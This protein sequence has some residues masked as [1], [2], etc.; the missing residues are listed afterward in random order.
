M[1]VE[2][3]STVDQQT[4][5]A[6]GPVSHQMPAAVGSLA[7]QHWWP[8][9]LNLRPL[10]KNSPLIDPM[11]DGFDYAT[12]F[13]SLDLEAMKTDFEEVMKTSEP[14]WP[15][16]YGHYGAIDHPDGLAQ[17]RHVPHLRRERWRWIGHAS[18][19]AAQHLA[20]QRQPGQ[21]APTAMAGQ[22]G[23][24][25]RNLVGR[26]DDPRGECGAGVDG[27][28]RRAR[29]RVGAGGGHLLGT[30]DRVAGR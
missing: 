7:N 30:R 19:R 12:E 5:D 28:R 9:Q 11:G 23:V 26:S 24:R 16:D 2:D 21:G 1:T 10:N 4:S 15:A 25:S 20:R 29:G 18:L 17:R 14:W 3:I 8:E 6:E 13:N 27:L 22:V